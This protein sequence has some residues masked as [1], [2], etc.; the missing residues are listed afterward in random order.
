MLI[1]ADLSLP[2]IVSPDDYQ[3]VTSPQVGVSRMMLDRIGGECARATSIVRY[4]PGSAFSRHAHPGGEEIF[5][6]DGVF[7]D[8]TGDYPAGWYLRNPPGSSHSPS[9]RDGA[10]I[11]V[12]LQQMT[13]ADNATVRVDTREPSNWR[14]QSGRR[15]CHLYARGREHVALHVVE[16][17]QVILPEW[18]G[19]LELLVIDG[20]VRLGEACYTAGSWLR[21]PVNNHDTFLSAENRAKLLLKTGVVSCPADISLENY[22]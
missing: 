5:V 19:C 21:L 4:Q 10:T 6:L 11:F 13:P 20:A 14:A 9:S 12:K 16:G 1:N 22:P 7:S 3:W 15:V 2:A 18:R 17:G 8:E